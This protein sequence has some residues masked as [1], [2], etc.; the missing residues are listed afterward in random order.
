M[1]ALRKVK[2]KTLEEI[3]TLPL[4]SAPS[5]A[6]PKSAQTPTPGTPRRST[7][8]AAR[9]G[10]NTPASTSAALGAGSTEKEKETRIKSSSPPPADKAAYLNAFFL[11]Q[12]EAF[13]V[14]FMNYFLVP[15]AASGTPANS[16]SGGMAVATLGEESNGSDQRLPAWVTKDTR[17]QANLTREQTSEASTKV[18]EAVSNMI[19]KYLDTIRSFL[20]YPVSLTLR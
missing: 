17:A 3:K 18:K 9:N 16:N 8:K 2:T 6:S 4:Y 5:A 12:L 19:S 7:K 13:V 14:S 15:T 1:S 20:D 10:P 11:K